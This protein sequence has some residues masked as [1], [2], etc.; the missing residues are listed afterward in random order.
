MKSLVT[1][2]WRLMSFVMVMALIGGGWLWQT[3]VARQI[4]TLPLLAVGQT[5]YTTVDVVQRDRIRNILDHIRLDMDALVALNLTAQQAET[6]ISGTR[7]WCENN[8]VTLQTLQED[9]HRKVTGVRTVEKTIAMGPHDVA[10]LDALALAR[11]EL[12][13]AK[14]SYE[15]SLASLKASID[16]QLSQS[17]QATWDAIKTGHGQQ[18]PI[19]MLDLTDTQRLAVSKA[20]RTYKRRRMASQ[21]GEQRSSAVTEY[22]SSLDQIFTVDQ[23]NVISAYLGYYSSSSTA[24]VN[25][26]ATVLPLPEIEG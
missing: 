26:M 3:A 5:S 7:T 18:M 23:K 8:E 22:E 12:G 1:K 17:Q 16:L 24:V 10:N 14:N 19:R 15:T 9:I 13:D 11:Q 2:H 6:L 4:T 25:A 20:Q 21:G